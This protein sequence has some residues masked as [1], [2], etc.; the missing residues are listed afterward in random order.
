MEKENRGFFS[1]LFDFSFRNFVTLR[2]VSV[3]YVLSILFWLFVALFIF[4]A[5]FFLNSPVHTVLYSLVAVFVFFAGVLFS[6]LSLETLT[7]LFRVAENTSEIAE[8]LKELKTER[9]RRLQR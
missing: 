1:V 7:V 3:L 2:L 4:G 5:S 6:R 8:I 9:G